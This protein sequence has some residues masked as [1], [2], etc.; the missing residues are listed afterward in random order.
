MLGVTIEVNGVS[1]HTYNDWKLGW[2]NV[3]ISSPKAKTYT[4][5][6][7]GSDGVLD[8]TE[9][10][11]GDIKYQNRKI[12]LSFDVEGDYMLW[13]EFYSEYLNFCHGQKA[14][15]ILDTDLSYYWIGRINLTSDKE[16]YRYGEV[17]LEI[18][19]EPYKY[20]MVNS[21]EDWLWDPFNFETGVIREY[22]DL[23]VNGTLEVI[24]QGSRK[25]QYLKVTSSA[26]M[27]VTFNGKS[28]TVP[29]GT[30][31]LLDI[32]LVQGENKLLFTGNGTISIDYR[33]GSL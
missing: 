33:G 23:A 32:K 26:N 18:D 22:K 31:E 1:K 11:L 5:E 12:K 20:D 24:I 2:T 17:T 10:L 30:S 21:S 3:E 28:Y 27:T 29:K 19:A 7:P 8:L 9:S 14:R 25:V 15:I 13:Q 6:I 4:I 16:D